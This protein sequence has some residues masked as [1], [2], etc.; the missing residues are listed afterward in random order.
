VT[1]SPLNDQGEQRETSEKVVFWEVL[2][3][4]D[5]P[6][7][8]SI[9]HRQLPLRGTTPWQHCPRMS[10]G[11]AATKRPSGGQRSATFPSHVMGIAAEI[12]HG[13]SNRAA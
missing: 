8:R 1:Q 11:L 3:M 10:F 5:H 4:A 9:V 7:S 12:A 6:N 13:L 2:H